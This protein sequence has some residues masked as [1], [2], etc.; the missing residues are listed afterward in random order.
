MRS[1]D[2][3]D[4]RPVGLSA[5]AKFRL[6]AALALILG[7]T[8]FVLLTWR[9]FF[10]YVSPGK[11]RVVVAKTG[12][13]VPP[14][15]ILAEEGEQGPQKKVL[16]EGWHFVMPIINTVEDEEQNT[17]IPAGKVGVVTAK[18][19]DPLPAG[20]ILANEG[21]K[22]I[23]RNVLLPGVYRLN[24]EGYSVKPVDAV[25][26]K[27]GFV[28]VQRRRLGADGTGRFA[29]NDNEKGI[30]HGLLQ[31]G[32]YY[33]N[34]EEY[35][36][37]QAEVGI[38]QTSFHAPDRDHPT[39][40]A[41]EFT[42]RGGFKIKMDCTIEW[43]VL[44]QDMADLVAEF[45]TRT[46]GN[47][48]YA[49]QE[50]VENIAIVQQA[51]AIVRDKGV[52]YGVQ[53]LLVGSNREKFQEDF[54]KELKKRC[55]A[56]RV[57]VRSAFIRNIEIPPEYMKQ[58]RDKQIAAETNLTNKFREDRYKSN[59]EVAKE[60]SAIENKVN[61]V[62]YETKKMV[63]AIDT[64]AKNIA[65]LNEAEIEKL[66]QEFQAQIAALDAQKSLEI[67]KAKTDVTKLKETA[68]SSLYKMKMD[69]FKNDGDAFLRYSLADQLNPD[70]KV[71]LFHSGPGTFWTN[72]GDKSMNL[73]LPVP[74]NGDK[75]ST[76]T[77]P[78]VGPPNPEKLTGKNK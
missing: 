31:P 73:L 38:E 2:I 58:I 35:E 21:E 16:G 75:I 33:L 41:I 64:E 13:A 9:T 54:R 74:G 34:P 1:D 66:N 32:I 8:V 39:D 40:T 62:E 44:P 25:E 78:I 61:E 7:V 45:G 49:D 27:A 15:H 72:M 6:I 12:K 55:E 47:S 50:K 22:G 52:E 4:V 20:R 46:K 24:Q 28:G 70:L 77:K 68:K 5:K 26:V 11:H 42:S 19:G 51:Q 60:E 36:V 65:S 43:E 3:I 59:A 17:V 14:G 69:V 23:Q 37:I 63:T 30:L 76:P 10:K 53:D 56:K 57:V 67:G 71:R 48:V 18:G 29:E